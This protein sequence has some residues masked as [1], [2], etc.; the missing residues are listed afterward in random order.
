M[1][2]SQEFYSPPNSALS[3]ELLGR[4]ANMPAHH[5]PRSV[6]R[7]LALYGAGNLGR[8]AREYFDRLGIPLSLVT[9]AK[10]E[11]FRRDPFWAGTRVMPPADVDPTTRKSVLL[12]V[13]VATSPYAKL[14][15]GLCSEGWT[16]VV[17]FYDIAEAYRDRHPLSNGWFAAP[18]TARDL[19]NIAQVFEAWADDISRAHHLQFV[20][21]RRLR[22]EWLFKGAPVN[23]ENRFFIPEVSAA[24]TDDE[25]FVDIGAHTGSVTLRFIDTVHSRFR[26]IWAV[27]PDSENL[28]GL[29]TAISSLP[30][31]VRDR[32]RLIPAVVGSERGERTFF[33]G[34]GYAS[35]C[36]A[37][38]QSSLPMET[39]DDLG[40]SP[41]F[42]KLH[43]E[44]AELDALKGC[45]DTI[46]RHR[47]IVVT[48][49]YHNHQGLWE[50][51]RWLMGEL[52]HYVFYMRM[53]GWCGTG[54]VV[55]C[56]PGERVQAR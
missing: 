20:A 12:A 18:L 15:E 23:T 35:Q 32:I 39:I 38:G 56:I 1:I 48:T 40:L 10:A 7:P 4:I 8:M 3:Q 28:R 37:L 2:T 11:Q 16:D 6:D 54:A 43:L 45:R 41:S 9:D 13:C 47:P 44:G 19:E 30:A 22:H 24:L 34:L 52:P 31:P 53:H 55:Y 33:E 17:P 14:A 29:R 25:S 21:W 5:A 27:E 49:S 36:S 42:M 26:A 46:L 51:P 50:L